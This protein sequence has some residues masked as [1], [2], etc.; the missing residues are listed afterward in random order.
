MRFL[1]AILGSVALAGLFPGKAESVFPASGRIASVSFFPQ[2]G[3]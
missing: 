3:C 1:D 2:A